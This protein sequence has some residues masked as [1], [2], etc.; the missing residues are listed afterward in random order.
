MLRLHRN[1]ISVSGMLIM[2]THKDIRKNVSCPVSPLA[3]GCKKFQRV[4]TSTLAAETVSLNTVPDQLSWV[5]L[6]WG[7]L[8]D[9]NINWK[10]PSKTLKSITGNIF[11]GHL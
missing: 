4:A 9:P 11:H 1:P 6:C 8:F 2:G 7:W 5:R 3:L 10:Q